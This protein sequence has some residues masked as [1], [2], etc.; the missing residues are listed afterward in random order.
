MSRGAWFD[1]EGI[2]LFGPAIQR[3][4]SFERYAE[5]GVIT[6]AE[7]DEQEERVETL[8]RALEPKLPDELH[9]EFTELLTELGVLVQISLL[10][11][12]KATVS[13]AP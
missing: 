1:G 13:E 5:D 9:T 4:A 3:L 2:D 7:L 10:H 12:R 8:L 6:A 11:G